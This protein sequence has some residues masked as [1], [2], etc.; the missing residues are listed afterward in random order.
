MVHDS[1]Q[2]GWATGLVVW[3]ASWFAGMQRVCS[4]IDYE[5]SNCKLLRLHCPAKQHLAHSTGQTAPHWCVLCLQICI[6]CLTCMHNQAQSDPE[7]GT[8]CAAGRC[9]DWLAHTAEGV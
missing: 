8:K 3:L 9:E 5:L 1:G 4:S 2:R 6:A 7:D